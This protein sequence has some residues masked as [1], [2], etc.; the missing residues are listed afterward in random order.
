M[1]RWA[2]RALTGASR[3]AL[4]LL[5]ALGA[6]SGLSWAA[7]AAGL[8]QPLIVVSGS[9]APAIGTGDLLIAVAVPADALAVGDVASLP[10][11]HGDALVTHRVTSLSQDGDE[12]AV[13]MKGDANADPDPVVYRLTPH[14]HVWR[15]AVTLPGVGYV[16]ARVMR[17]AVTVPLLVGVL[18]LVALAPAGTPRRRGRRRGRGGRREGRRAQTAPAT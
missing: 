3:V 15:E 4:W 18:A 17:P 1:R 11:P 13:R 5:V 7:T 14:Q 2:D 8:A 6:V 12:L 10:H 9:M 16:A